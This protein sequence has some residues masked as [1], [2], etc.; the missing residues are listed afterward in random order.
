MFKTTL[1][2]RFI[3]S[4]EGLYEA[5][6]QAVF[7]LV[8]VMRAGR[9]GHPLF[10]VSI[11]F[12][13]ISSVMA[14]VS[15][16]NVYIAE[17][18][19]IVQSENWK[20]LLINQIRRFLFRF[21][22]I[23]ARV[24]CLAIFWTVVGGFWFTFLII[25]ELS[26]PL[27][28]NF[29]HYL[30]DDE[31][32][33]NRDFYL[34]INTIIALPIEWVFEAS[35]ITDPYDDVFQKHCKCCSCSLQCTVLAFPAVVLFIVFQGLRWL[36]CHPFGN[37]DYFKYASLR[38]FVTYLEWGIIILNFVLFE[39][40]TT[41]YLI[42]TKHCF[43]LTIISGVF[44]CIFTMVYPYLMI[45][46]RLPNNLPANS[47]LAYAYLG[48]ISQLSKLYLENITLVRFCDE[49]FQERMRK[50]D[51]SSGG[52]NYYNHEKVRRTVRKQKLITED[53]HKLLLKVFT[54][55]EIQNDLPVQQR[56]YN[57]LKILRLDAGQ[58]LIEN[59]IAIEA[60]DDLI[61]EIPQKISKYWHKCIKY[62]KKNDKN[63]QQEEVIR[64]LTERGAT[65]R[66][67]MSIF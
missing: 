43:V 44:L 52:S 65:N 3:R 36:V 29:Q 56:I 24:G 6:V 17:A 19:W 14:A 54:K 31:F 41:T 32:F 45:D 61:D 62:V 25:G 39:D 37:N 58:Q 42:S 9:A 63:T 22:E 20:K 5:S 55:L 16:D 34:A 15:R 48:N 30:H 49:H 10:L 33:S 2:F 23:I 27:Y 53:A 21:L 26:V 13:I 38:L 67:R 8:Y 64:W 40:K 35:N 57:P 66:H 11:I 46:L 1:R 60:L 4:L 47:K 12:S 59:P 51:S 28:Y 50:I 18:E 7:Q